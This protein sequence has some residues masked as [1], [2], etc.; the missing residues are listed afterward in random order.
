ML[1]IFTLIGDLKLPTDAS[2]NFFLSAFGNVM[3]GFRFRDNGN[4]V[5]NKTLYPSLMLKNRD[6]IH[7]LSKK[8]LLLELSDNSLEF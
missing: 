4:D 8:K 3:D 1:L 6:K 5:N 2:N 7:K